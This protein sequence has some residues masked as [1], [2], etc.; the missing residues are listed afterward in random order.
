MVR[1]VHVQIV[2][3][4][5][6]CRR[7]ALAPLLMGLMMASIAAR[8]DV[9][10]FLEE[11]FGTFGGM[12]PTGHSSVYLSRVCAASLTS[13]RRCEPEERGVVISRYHRIDGY[14][15]LAVPLIPY[16][17]AVDAADQ[18]PEKTSPE[19]E[20]ALRDEYRRKYLEAVAPDGPNGVTPKGDWIQL[21]GAAYDRRIYCFEIATTEEQDDR[22]IEAFNARRNV[23]RF[24]IMFHNCA[25]FARQVIDFYYPRA[26]H[27]SLVADLGIMTPK[28]AAKCLVR[29]AK[30]H[31]DL[32]FS[33]FR[34]TQVPGT[35]PRSGPVRGVLESVVKSKR[36]IVPLA[37]LT[38]VQPYLG[39]GLV[40]AWVESEHNFNP[41]QLTRPPDAE[42]SPE[43]FARELESNQAVLSPAGLLA[44][45]PPL[46]NLPPLI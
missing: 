6:K 43:I 42:A 37:P 28:Q 17:Y 9:A 19:A 21:V 32:R 24:N 29:Y 44:N 36:Y 8:A 27:R 3:S 12:N 20:A 33:S 40:F 35:I 30:H 7:F 1:R 16:L 31:P 5:M 13:L 15:W 18:V 46:L 45:L 10:I 23:N 4:V 11:P 41:N 26:I 22:F 38:I 34:I 2:G 14:D 39:G 25:D